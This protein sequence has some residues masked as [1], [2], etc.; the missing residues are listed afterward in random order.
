MCELFAM[1]SSRP[2]AITYSMREFSR[3]GG[4][5]A[6]NA[7]GWGIAYLEH[8]DARVFRDV[9]AAADSPYLRFVTNR[10]FQ[11]EIVVSHIRKAT[12]GEIAL[13]NTQPFVRELGGRIHLF[14]HN[15]DLHGVDQQPALQLARHQPIGETDSEYAFCALLGRLS[16]L[17]SDPESMPGLAERYR[18]VADFARDIGPL[19]PA[20]FVYTDGD[21][22]FLHGNQ[23]KDPRDRVVRP[24]GLHL[25]C[26]SCTAGD[27]ELQT[28]GLTVGAA[29]QHVVLAASIPLTDEHW[30]ALDEGEVVVL[31]HGLVVPKTR[32]GGPTNGSG[33]SLL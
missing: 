12:Q 22:V 18:V 10:E 14:A 26:R 6:D 15:G 5:T 27:S 19:G 4:L 13:R 23:R 2:A 29:T 8:G 25:L 9:D 16:H 21:A 30:V 1:S 11:S 3:H 32:L 31:Q 7:D 33:S 28:P 24:P 20:N 17:W